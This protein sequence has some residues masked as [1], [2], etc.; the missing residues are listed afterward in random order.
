[1]SDGLQILT[2]KQAATFLNTSLSTI[3]RLTYAGDLPSVRYTERQVR[4]RLQDLEQWVAS[5]VEG[6]KQ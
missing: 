6:P 2:A 5:R 1:M 3:R 4:Y